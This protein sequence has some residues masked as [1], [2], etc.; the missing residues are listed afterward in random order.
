[1]KKINYNLKELKDML[2]EEYN[3]LD[4]F[5]NETE[6]HF[7]RLRNSPNSS[8]LKFIADQTSNIAS[9]RSNK[10]NIIKEMINL[11][12][13]EIDTQVKEYNLNKGEDGDD[14]AIKKV[15]TEVYNILKT[16]EK[17][18]NLSELFNKS[19]NENNNDEDEEDILN[20][21]MESINKKKEKEKL[22][23]EE[24]EKEKAI[25]GSNEKIIEE[26]KIGDEFCL[27]ADI[28]GNVYALDPEM[29]NI[30]ED[31]DTS[32]YKVSLKE[33][34]DGSYIALLDDGTEIP[35][36]DIVEEE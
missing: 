6:T 14:A 23:K 28:Y 30:I 34:E 20:K 2:K 7:Q 1:M 12:K 22:L 31:I 25:Y 18:V 36:I 26:E 16:K 5:L 33:T 10:V 4:T 15:S 29:E 19:L 24:N 9:I 21:R 3:D 35:L 32:N 11:E 13:I 27:A 8:S 17:T